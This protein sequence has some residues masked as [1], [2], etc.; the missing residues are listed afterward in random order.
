MNPYFSKS[1]I[2]QLEPFI[3]QRVDMLCQ[4]LMRQSKDGPVELHTIYLAF[5]NDTVCSFA[6]DYSMNLLEDPGLARQWKATI[7][8]IASMTPLFKQF[9]WLHS[10]VDLVPKSILRR[11]LPKFARIQSLRAVSLHIGIPILSDTLKF[12][13]RPL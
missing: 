13:Y 12:W 4:S 1:S 7:S 8:A 5:A 6:F 11:Y 3:Q 9:P 2:A 10:V